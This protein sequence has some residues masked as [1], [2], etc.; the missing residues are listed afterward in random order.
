MPTEGR[1]S[2]RLPCA[3]T[4]AAQKGSAYGADRCASDAPY[5]APRIQTPTIRLR[6]GILRAF[7]SIPE[8]SKLYAFGAAQKTK[9]FR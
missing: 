1:H 3:L 6:L 7:D 4:R 2:V 5:R 8:F 9:T